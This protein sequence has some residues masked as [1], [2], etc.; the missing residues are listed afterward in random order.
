MQ[1]VVFRL[2]FVVVIVRSDSANGRQGRKTFLLLG[3][4]NGGEYRKYKFD[5]NMSVICKRKCNCPFKLQGKPYEKGV[6]WVLKVLCD[7]HN[8]DVAFLISWSPICW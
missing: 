3:C 6:G 2:D 1:E 5:M 4:D 8:H 7:T